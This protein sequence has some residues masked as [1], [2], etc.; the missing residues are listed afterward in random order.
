MPAGRMTTIPWPGATSPLYKTTL[1]ADYTKLAGALGVTGT[2]VVEASPWIEDND[3]ILG[4]AEKDQVIVGFVGNLSEVWKDAAKF[5]EAVEKY[6]KNPLF[7]GIRV[8]GGQVGPA[9]NMGMQLDN[10]KQLAAKDL[11][12]DVNGVSFA[13]IDKLAMQ[14]PTLRIVIDHMGPAFKPANPPEAAWLAAIDMVAKRSNVFMKVSY[15]FEAAKPR[16][17]MAPTDPALY[18]PSLD[19]VW[20]AFGE[21]R[22]I[23][24][25]NWPVSEPAA[26]LA[27]V[28][29]LVKKYIAEKGKTAEEKFFAGNARKVYKWVQR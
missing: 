25:T 9:V 1:P 20:K 26:P 16:D 13:D 14:V 27:Q 4:L 15:L 12:V 5:T 10:F 23:Y 2:V 3:W 22:L 21:D 17:G 8:G 7:R 11:M 28:H 18:R 19:A 24:G 29:D 6:A